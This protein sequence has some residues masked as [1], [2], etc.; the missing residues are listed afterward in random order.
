MNYNVPVRIARY[1]T[2]QS[3]HPNGEKIAQLLKEMGLKMV[4]VDEL[5]ALMDTAV[6]VVVLDEQ[7]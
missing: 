4:R 3:E 7:V 6:A 1:Q 2:F 5:G